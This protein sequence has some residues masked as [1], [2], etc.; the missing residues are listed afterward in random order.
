MEGVGWFGCLND[1]T[2]ADGVV[3]VEVGCG[4]IGKNINRFEVVYAG[5]GQPSPLVLSVAL[6]YYKNRS[7]VNSTMTSRISLDFS[8]FREVIDLESHLEV[9]MQAFV[10]LGFFV[11]SFFQ[12]F[13]SF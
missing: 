4:T 5:K 6:S 1:S 13:L 9:R 12:L 10:I 3:A 2:V 7:D 8:P 11:L